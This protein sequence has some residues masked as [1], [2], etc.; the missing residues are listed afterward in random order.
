MALGSIASFD[1]LV[2]EQRHR[3]RGK[4]INIASDE[5]AVTECAAIISRQSGT[6][7]GYYRTPLEQVR[8]F[9][10]DFAAI[11]MW[12]DRVGQRRYRGPAQGLSRS[13]LDAFQGLGCGPGLEL[14]EELTTG[15]RRA[16][17]KSAVAEQRRVSLR[18]VT[19]ST[20]EKA[21]RSR[22]Q[23]EAPVFA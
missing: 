21:T 8:Q 23:S 7:I 13:A 2:L 15:S 18:Y 14:A 3:F 10:E 1:A 4:R 6:K 9:T 16:A 20:S 11:E 22:R 17:A 19:A 12:F 5:L